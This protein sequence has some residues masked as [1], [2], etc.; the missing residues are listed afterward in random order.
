MPPDFYLNATQ[1]GEVLGVSRQ[2]AMQYADDDP[3][4]PEPAVI[5]GTDRGWRA[6]DIRRYKRLRERRK[7]AAT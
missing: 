1:V 4:F 6:A 2:R 7:K 3:E 5:V